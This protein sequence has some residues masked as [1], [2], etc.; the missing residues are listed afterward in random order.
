M[1]IPSS[2]SCFIPECRREDGVR[3]IFI[4]A[5]ERSAAACPDHDGAAA[6]LLY[7]IKGHRESDALRAA[8]FA[9]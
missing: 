7:T 1:S 6:W 9:C 2:P 4:P 5:F 8:L 3:A